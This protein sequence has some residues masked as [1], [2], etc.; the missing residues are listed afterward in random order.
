MK[1]SNIFLAVV[2]FILGLVPGTTQAQLSA[3]WVIPA[4]ANTPGN[5]NT[6]WR[7]DL[8]IHNPQSWEIPV[9]VQFLETG[10]VNDHVPTLDLVIYPY[11]TVNLWDVL[12]PDLFDING[13]GA[14]LVYVPPEEPCPDLECHFLATSRTYTD[15]PLGG[16]GEF[17]QAL[18]G[19]SLLEGVDWLTFGYAAGILNDGTAFRCNIGVASW[20]PE[21]TQV[22]V[23]VQ[24]ANGVIID[25]EIFDLPPFGHLQRR[26]HTSVTGGSLVYYLVDGPDDSWVYPY[27]SVVN[28]ST[29]DPSYFYGRYSGVGVVSKTAIKRAP[30]FPETGR[31]I[32]WARPHKER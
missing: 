8:S 12:G 9:L 3:N 25:T 11:E 13:T 16:E 19:A 6:Y 15:D 23:D 27:A 10:I 30:S 4:S 31:T 21:W 7:T 5:G 1:S 29:G 32:H 14:I 17:G 18:P 26:L 28:Q 2:I 20:T 22:A 24:D